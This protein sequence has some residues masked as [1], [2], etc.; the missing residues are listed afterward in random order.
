MSTATELMIHMT[1]GSGVPERAATSKHL[2]GLFSNELE[3]SLHV[4]KPGK[5]KSVNMWRIT[6][7]RESC[8]EHFNHWRE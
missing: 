2:G 6:G 5:Q 8:E 3:I 4:C 1:P 7:R